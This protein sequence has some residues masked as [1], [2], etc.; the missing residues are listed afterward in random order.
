M[1]TFFFYTRNNKQRNTRARNF[2]ACGSTNT[3]RSNFHSLW[4]QKRGRSLRSLL[5]RRLQSARLQRR[6]LRRPSRRPQRRRAPRSV[7]SFKEF[8][9]KNAHRAFLR[10]GTAVAAFPLC[11][12]SCHAFKGYCRS[13]CA[14]YACG[15]NRE[16]AALIECAGNMPEVFL[17]CDPVGPERPQ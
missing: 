16:V 5:Q 15:G 13:C 7:N 11:Q 10:L 14:Q 9:R 6:Q 4:Q 2:L 3:S 12:F 8:E 17:A 1:H